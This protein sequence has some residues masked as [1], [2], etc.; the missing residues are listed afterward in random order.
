MIDHA[1]SGYP[2]GALAAYCHVHADGTNSPQLYVSCPAIVSQDGSEPIAADRMRNA[3]IQKA[4]GNPPLDRSPHARTRDAV[5]QQTLINYDFVILIAAC[6]NI[7]RGVFSVYFNRFKK[8]PCR[9][10]AQFAVVFEDNQIPYRHFA[11]CGRMI[12]LK[13]IENGIT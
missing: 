5:R 11:A 12:M 7:S 10:T 1:R 3:V 9:R 6:R 2:H 8:F 13:H 4:G